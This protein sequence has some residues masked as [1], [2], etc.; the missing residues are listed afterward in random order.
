M[1]IHTSSTIIILKDDL[2]DKINL[3]N[4]IKSRIMKLHKW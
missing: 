3:I 2:L 4:L 1:Y